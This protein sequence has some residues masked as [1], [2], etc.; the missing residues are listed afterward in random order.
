LKPIATVL[1]AGLAMFS[2][3]AAFA[4][5]VEAGPGINVS[6][7]GIKKTVQFRNWKV[8]LDTPNKIGTVSTGLFCT[9]AKDMGYSTEYNK[10]FLADV[11]QTFR[12]KSLALGYPR[13]NGSDSAFAEG[14]ISSAD[15]R[16]GFTLLDINQTLCISGADV[17]GS[18]KL[19]LKAEL[20]SNK[21]QKV[22]YS[23]IVE[24]TFSTDN[25]VQLND[26]IRKLIGNTLDPMFADQKYADN[27]R[28]NATAGA[29]ASASGT[30]APILVKNGAR[31]ADKVTKD[32][33]GILSTVV[34]IETGGGSGSGF[35][36]GRD[37]YVITNQH[38]VGDARYVKVK[39]G[40][41]Y[42]VPGEVVRRNAARD[43]ALIKTDIEPPT[44]LFVRTTAPRIGEEVFA[45]GSPFGAQLNSTVTRGVLSGERTMDEKRF[46]QSDVAI[47][48]GN[49]GGP[50][51][52]ADG[53]LIAVADLKRN[54]ASGIGLFIPIEEVLATLGLNV[55]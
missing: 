7:D 52:D 45:V 21:L 16:M 55:Q 47:N 32:S 37:G 33:K 6:A 5:T 41:G 40:D 30:A 34:T 8:N 51:V 49:S 13:F 53:A 1:A 27:F 38:V 10:L 54:N 42:A 35:Y 11:A 44:A 15:Y 39:M 3:H 50:L 46:L 12:D 23:R 31:Q 19:K 36:I 20:F 18:G 29:L 4:D 22:V 17:S 43:V 48:P 14:E 9:G 24:G 2:V 28:E 26:F 25:K